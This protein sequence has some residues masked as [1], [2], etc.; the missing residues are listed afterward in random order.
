MSYGNTGGAGRHDISFYRT[1]RDRRP[2]SRVLTGVL[3]GD[4]RPD[5][6]A[7]S[8]ALLRKM[9]T[10]RRPPGTPTPK[11]V[12]VLRAILDEPKDNAEMAQALGISHSAA[13]GGA[14]AA[15]LNGFACRVGQSRY[16]QKFAISD[17][18]RAA[19]EA[20]PQ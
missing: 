12:A 9:A 18:G 2:P 10:K 15:V 19:L 11:V 14:S 16:G 5:R 4:P 8:E 3:L 17:E 7:V 1:E 20:L 6:D 13:S